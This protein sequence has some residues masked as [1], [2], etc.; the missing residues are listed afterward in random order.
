MKVR[1]LSVFDHEETPLPEDYDVGIRRKGKL[2][3]CPVNELGDGY[4]IETR[5]LY[6]D[7][8]G[9]RLVQSNLLN[10]ITWME[11]EPEL[12]KWEHVDY[13]LGVGGKALYV[14]D[15]RVGLM[16]H[17]GFL[18]EAEKIEER[19]NEAVEKTLVKLPYYHDDVMLL[20][21]YVIE[22]KEVC[23]EYKTTAKRIY[24][25]GMLIARCASEQESALKEIRQKHIL[26]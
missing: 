4:R 12:Y 13:H 21:N 11:L 14:P 16:F 3:A 2:I 18:K 7:R 15:E 1:V 23:E 17:Y 25:K 9:V 20:M 24:D 8:R 19:Y 6:G 10:I 26:T 22:H 5:G